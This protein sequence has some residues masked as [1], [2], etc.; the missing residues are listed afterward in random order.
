MPRKTTILIVILAVITGIL[1]FLAVRNDT[2]QNTFKTST[3]TTPATPTTTQPYA[4]LAFGTDILDLTALPTTQIVDVVVDTDNKPIAGIQVELSYD[5]KVFTNVRL[6]PAANPFFGPNAAVLINSVD[7]T[8][9]RVSYAVGIQD[10]N[11]KIGKGTVVRLGFTA[12]KFA[13]VA[14]SAITFLSKSA[15]TSLSVPD[16]IL[17]NFTPLQVILTKP[18]TPPN[19]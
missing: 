7:P 19:P 8:Q 14:S 3:D 5:P 4:T 17:K 1:I 16:S 13:G 9:G 11:E 2:T 10:G 18:T 12:N 15:V 6:L